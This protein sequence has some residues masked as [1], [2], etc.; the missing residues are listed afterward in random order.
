[1]TDLTSTLK[2]Q[3]REK[4]FE[5]L[6]KTKD[7]QNLYKKRAE[8]LEKVRLFACGGAEALEKA[9]KDAAKISKLLK[10]LPP[11][12]Q[13]PKP[14]SETGMLYHASTI[15]VVYPPSRR[16]PDWYLWNGKKYHP[17]IPNDITD[18]KICPPGA[19]TLPTGYG[20]ITEHANLLKEEKT[21]REPFYKA[22]ALLAEKLNEHKTVESLIDEWLEVKDFLPTEIDPYAPPSEKVSIVALNEVYKL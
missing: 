13:Y 10:N 14:D 4:A 12:L 21:L 9:E 11:A 16:P 20:F 2:N 7:M 19:I 17:N 6:E 1:M 3:I 8:W 22:D 18:V 5:K 15:G